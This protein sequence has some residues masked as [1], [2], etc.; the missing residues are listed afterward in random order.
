M[1]MFRVSEL[2]EFIGLDATYEGS[3]SPSRLFDD[4]SKQNE[5][6]RLEAYKQ[7]FE[8]RKQKRG[9]KKKNKTLDDV[10]NASWG[11]ADFISVDGSREEGISTDDS[12]DGISLDD[13]GDGMPT[14][15]ISES[16]DYVD[17]AE[18]VLSN[19]AETNRRKQTP[20]QAPNQVPYFKAVTEL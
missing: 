10:M 12:G 9:R 7:R 16:Q 6:K 1:K 15:L 5:E 13:S 11:H 2:D 18:Y 14:D 3:D 20:E 19:N 4:D 17:E 8:E